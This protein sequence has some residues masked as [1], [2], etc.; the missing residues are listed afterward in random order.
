[1]AASSVEF[2]QPIFMEEVQKYQ[3][4]Y[5]KFSKDYKNKYVRLNCWKAI[6]EKFGMDPPEAERRYKNIRTAYG[7]F[8]KKR[9]SI[10]SGSGRNAVPAPAEFA[11]L[12][13]LDIHINSRAETVTNVAI[14]D[15]SD[16]EEERGDVDSK[17]QESVDDELQRSSVQVEEEITNSDNGSRAS[18]SSFT[19]GTSE[20]NH[21]NP[22]NKEKQQKT[23]GLRKP[24]KLKRK[25]TTKEDVDLALLKTASTLAD[26]VIN[27]ESTPKR[28]EGDDEEDEDLLYCKSLARRFKR[29]SAP[30]KA[31]VR[32]QIEQLLYD[33]EYNQQQQPFSSQQRSVFLMENPNVGHHLHQF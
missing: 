19:A 24:G 23:I 18:T 32:L 1:M 22:N 10:P 33:T 28:R 17:L 5:D 27:A 20:E 14:P 29:M 26:K 7:R 16:S 6:G 8:L 15:A 30:T 4:L 2:S 21:N 13:W 11:N 25:S 31:F 12:E 3:C 9:K